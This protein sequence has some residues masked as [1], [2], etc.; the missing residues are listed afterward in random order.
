METSSH[1]QH[2]IAAPRITRRYQAES[3]HNERRLYVGIDIGSTSSDVVILNG[4]NE[5]IFC[6]YRRTA[7]RPVE[8]ARAQLKEMFGLINPSTKRKSSGVSTL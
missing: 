7:G 1:K 2:D 6:D 4:G 5:V 8:T 3:L